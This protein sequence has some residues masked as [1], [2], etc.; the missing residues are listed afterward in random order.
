VRA[1]LLQQQTER[2]QIA[3]PSFL[4]SHPAGAVVVVVT[5]ESLA[6]MKSKPPAHLLDPR[7]A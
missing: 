2:R 6:Q 7:L 3:E 1:Y 4:I 5:G